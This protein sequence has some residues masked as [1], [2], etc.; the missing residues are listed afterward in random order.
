MHPVAALSCPKRCRSAIGA[1]FADSRLVLFGAEL[2]QGGNTTVFCQEEVTSE[3]LRT[4]AKAC[5]STC[6]TSD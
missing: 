4:D 2:A 6:R 5:L 3:E 1:V